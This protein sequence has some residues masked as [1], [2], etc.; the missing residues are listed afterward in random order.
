MMYDN[1]RVPSY[2]SVSSRPCRLQISRWSL[3]VPIKHIQSPQTAMTSSSFY[4]PPTTIQKQT[5][6]PHHANY[7]SPSTPTTPNHYERPKSTI[8]CDSVTKH[9]QSTFHVND[10]RHRFETKPLVGIV[11]PMVHQRSCNDLNNSK[12]HA[13]NDDMTNMTGSFYQN[14]ARSSVHSSMPS[15]CPSTSSVLYR[16]RKPSSQNNFNGPPPIVPRRYS[17]INPNHN[18]SI[19]HR[20]S[21][22]TSTSSSIVIT[23]EISSRNS[24]D[25][26][27]QFDENTVIVDV[28]RLEMFYGSV[29]TLVKASHS[30]AYLYMTTTRQLANFEDW[31]CQQSGVPIWIYNTVC[32][33]SIHI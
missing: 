17:S 7:Y 1:S 31:S 4:F 23:N 24:I 8:V 18:K 19:S 12:H 26:T 22:T 30:I 13:K 33:L 20:S 9:H 6:T 11:K 2:T 3:D 15:P 16:T 28:K 21:R 27:E 10:L 14:S 25:E 32:S 29:G 5:L